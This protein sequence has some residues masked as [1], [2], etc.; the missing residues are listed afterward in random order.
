[1]KSVWRMSDEEVF[2]AI[3][4]LDPDVHAALER[5]EVHRSKSQFRFRMKLAFVVLSIAAIVYFITLRYLPAIV[6]FLS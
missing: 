3:R 4:Y 2:L 6:R 1:M 5:H